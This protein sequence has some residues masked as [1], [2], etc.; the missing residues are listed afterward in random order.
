MIGAFIAV[1]A[2]QPALEL[3]ES[4]TEKIA[5]AA[6]NVAKHYDVPISSV[7]QAW[8]GLAATVGSIYY[9]KIVA[10]RAMRVAENVGERP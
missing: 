7:T 1:R 3:D 9:G 5:G 6:A 4:E 8:F 10:I 2:K